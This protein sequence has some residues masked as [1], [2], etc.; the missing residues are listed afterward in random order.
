MPEK[1]W[2]RLEIFLQESLE[3]LYRLDF[4]LPFPP[5]LVSSPSLSVLLLTFLFLFC[6]NEKDITVRGSNAE[7]YIAI[8][9]NLRGKE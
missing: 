6:F 9:T 3:F 7:S 1:R 4:I 8:N 5:D 2:K